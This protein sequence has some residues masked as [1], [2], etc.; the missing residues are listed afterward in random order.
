MTQ[1]PFA[2]LG[3][4]GAVMGGEGMGAT[5]TSG[6]AHH[7]RVAAHSV[8]GRHQRPRQGKVGHH[9]GARR[10]TARRRGNV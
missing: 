10:P 7:M 1:N 8:S 4:Q 9:K 6:F 3:G 2:D 5:P